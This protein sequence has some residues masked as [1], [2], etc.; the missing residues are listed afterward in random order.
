MTPKVLRRGLQLSL[1]ASLLGVSAV[2]LWGKNYQDFLGSLGQIQPLWL[3]I[4]C[5]IASLDWIGGGLRHWI[6]SRHVRHQARPPDAGARCQRRPG[7]VRSHGHTTFVGVSR[8][9]IVPSPSR[10]R[11]LL[12]QQYAAP[13]GLS[14]QVWTKPTARLVK[15]TPAGITTAVGV[16]R[17]VVVPSPSCPRFQ[18]QQ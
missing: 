12:P 3:V 2:L 6:I 1:L 14:T 16:S 9:V 7:P 18:P 17:S 5:A 10:P 15:V 13:A 4:G 11:P 8:F